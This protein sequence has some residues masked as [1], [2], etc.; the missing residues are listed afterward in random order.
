VEYN[1]P[2]ATRNATGKGDA[3]DRLLMVTQDALVGAQAFHLIESIEQGV[4]PESP[5]TCRKAG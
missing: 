1:L 5:S 4:D 3:D 2:L